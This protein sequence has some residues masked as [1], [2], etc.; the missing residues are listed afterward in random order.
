MI[1]RDDLPP[2]E[3]W[4][5]GLPLVLFKTDLDIL[6]TWAYLNDASDIVLSAGN[7]PAI[8]RYGRVI[9]I[10]SRLLGH[11][12][13]QNLCNA[14]SDGAG[15]GVQAGR[16]FDFAYEVPNLDQSGYYRF[17]SNITATAAGVS[18]TLRA[19]PEFPPTIESYGL[20]EPLCRF[21]RLNRGLILVTG[22]TG[23]GKT[24]MLAGVLHSRLLEEYVNVVTYESPPEFIYTGLPNLKGLISQTDVPNHL[25]TY[26]HAVRN[27]LRRAPQIVLVGEARD[28]ET[29]DGMVTEVRTGHTV[30][31]TVHTESAPGTIDRIIRSFPVDQWESARVS[32]LDSVRVIVHQRL[33]PDT[34]GKRVALREWIYFDDRLKERLLDLPL[35]DITKFL[36]QHIRGEPVDGDRRAMETHARELFL[37]GRISRAVYH[38]TLVSLGVTRD[39]PRAGLHPEA[40]LPE[41]AA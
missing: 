6:L 38:V 20:E 22:S 27:S 30:Y 32:I 33:V 1:V 24:T 36:N 39:S 31:S 40:F 23:S 29:I 5:V 21:M 7:P 19:I 28:A 13:M 15:S 4:A 9:K 12:E 17:R 37:E 41:D 3:G 10:G 25:A 26:S 8:L 18:L 34:K 11:Q 2:I 16:D 35:P 14:V